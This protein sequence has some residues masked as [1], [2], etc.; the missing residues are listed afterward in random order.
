MVANELIDSRKRFMVE[1]FIFKVDLEK[2]YDHVDWGFL[3][4]M[5]LRFGFGDT[6]RGGCKSASLLLPS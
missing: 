4:Y 5:L 6:R 1:C 3:D 2:V